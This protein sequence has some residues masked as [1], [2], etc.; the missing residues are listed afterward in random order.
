MRKISLLE[1][2]TLERLQHCWAEDWDRV[3]V[4]DDF[5]ALSI[6]NTN[7]YG[8]VVIGSQVRIS[9]TKMIKGSGD[10]FEPNVI[11][12]LNEGGDGNIILCPQLTA[13]L[14]YMM[15]N[16][17]AVFDFVK[18][19]VS[20]SATITATVIADGAIID[21]ATKLV[22]CYINSSDD[23]PTYIGS[24]VIMEKSV[25]ACG[26]EVTDGAK[27]YESFVGEAVHI[28]KG[29]SSEASCFFANAYMD[30]G[31]A[32]AA[33]C[34][35]FACSHHKST[36]LIGGEFSFYNAG[37]NTNQSNHAY[38][39]GPIHWG[40]LQ[41]GA[42]TASGCHILWP[43]TIG[44]FSMVMGK[45]TQHPNLEKLPFSY[46]LSGPEKT[47]I[48]PGVNIKTVGTWR[49]VNKWPKRD[50]RNEYARRDIITFDFPNPYI[51][52]YVREGR[53]ILLEMQSAQCD[54]EEYFYE[55]CYIKKAA[56]EKGIKYYDLILALADMKDDGTRYIDMLGMIARQT[57]IDAIYN[58]VSDGE[59]KSIDEILSLLPSVEVTTPPL[60]KESEAYAQWL[61][62]IEKDAKK[63]FRMGDVSEEQ[64][65]DFIKNIGWKTSTQL[66]HQ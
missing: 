57:D 41:R 66:L 27:I 54:A 52:Q 20:S 21:G 40:T 16:N 63:E 2:D 50:K 11:S 22:D 17:Q 46:V 48:V 34:G 12:V 53:N 49:D 9:D 18:K 29:F 43:A 39:M 15:M 5:D 10:P 7:F 55:N 51:M 26:A 25:T 35:P 32:C 24:D 8:Y 23:A 33:L 19:E 62:M 38:K 4:A 58:K 44:V 14:A 31:E 3:I 42:K 47:Y 28:G 30:N 65:H 61:A 56:L 59:I 37:S 6:R 45:L 60:N 36:L 1:M 13:Q 64:L